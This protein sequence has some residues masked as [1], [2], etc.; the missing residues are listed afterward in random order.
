MSRYRGKPQDRNVLERIHVKARKERFANF[1][2]QF[3]KTTIKNT[4]DGLRKLK[5]HSSRV[6]KESQKRKVKIVLFTKETRYKN[7]RKYVDICRKFTEFIIK[8]DNIDTK[9]RHFM[10]M[11]I[12][13]IIPVYHA[14]K[15]GISPY[16]IA[17]SGNL[18]KISKDD[19][20]KKGM[21]QKLLNG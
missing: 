1:I 20:Q 7:Y 3:R 9:D 8:R 16:L 19:N 14:Y 10:N 18:Q 17:M 21:Y 6:L 12:D 15:M 5:K 11:H 2:I 4:Q 13:H